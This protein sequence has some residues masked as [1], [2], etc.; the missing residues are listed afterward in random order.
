VYFNNQYEDRRGSA[1]DCEQWQVLSPV[2]GK[3]HGVDELNRFLHERFR[4]QA[5]E[6]ASKGTSRT[7]HPTGP[8]RLI[9]G[10]KVMATR[11][12][13]R[14]IWGKG[15]CLVSNGEIGLV[16]GEARFGA[17]WKGSTP[18]RLDVEFRTQLGTTFFYWPNN[19]GDDSSVVL[20]LAYALTVHKSQGSQFGIVF[21]VIP[22]PCFILGREL[23]YT[24]LTR[25]LDRVVLLVQGQA[26]DLRAYASARYSEVARRYTNL[27]RPPNM[28]ADEKAG[29]LEYR[30]I[31]RTARGELVRSISEVVVAD[32]LHA[33][34][35]D[36]HYEKPLRG[37]DGVERYP[38]FTAEDS[39][40]GVTV[41]WEHLGM[42]SNPEYS[43]RWEEKLVWYATMGLEPNGP[44]ND[45]GE[46]LVTSEN[47]LD[48]AIDSS[49]IRAQ[50]REVFG[51]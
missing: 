23:V 5:L 7:P 15:R 50:V 17:R 10:D 43:R 13:W 28:I 1:A 18:E 4:R 25:Q 3:G 39:A 40:T 24:A 21:V 9:Y 19:F 46:R 51:L 42:L 33:E 37:P 38:D 29:F 41:Y 36:Y 45:N 16:V 32:A 20:E 34:G 2:R 35:I 14:A 30:L 47:R 48:G 49:S 27:F 11:N 6:W 22:Q 31:H 44:E 12:E 26:A 8:Q